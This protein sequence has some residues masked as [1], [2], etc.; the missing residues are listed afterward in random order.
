MSFWPMSVASRDTGTGLAS[1]DRSKLTARNV[2][3]R[4]ARF[5]PLTRWPDRG[6]RWTR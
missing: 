5:A 4:G 6:V 3:I 2:T 1:K